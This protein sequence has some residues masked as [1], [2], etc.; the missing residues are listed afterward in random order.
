MLATVRLY[1][2]GLAAA[3][4]RQE[5]L[6]VVGAGDGGPRAIDLVGTYR[7]EVAIVDADLVQTPRFVDRL[8]LA[9]PPLLVIAF[10]VGDDDTQVV[11]CAEAGVAGYVSQDA[12]MVELIRVIAA[13]GR[14]EVRCSPQVAGNLFRRVGELARAGV[15]GSSPSPPAR[16][17]ETRARLDAVQLTAREGEIVTFI[18]GGLMNK[19]I[20][21]RLGISLSTVKNHVHHL[22][23][24]HAVG[25]RSDLSH[26]YQPWT[27]AGPGHPSGGDAAIPQQRGQG[28]G[29]DPDPRRPR[30]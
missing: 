7:P 18:C 19:E 24:K 26:L 28:P 12:G 30:P 6:D 16:T 2:E 27:D 21:R 1:R 14:G 23:E 9:H 8:R 22:L 20:A 5:G 15:P 17:A 11:S 25:S 3:L 29:P 10:A 4:A 13:A